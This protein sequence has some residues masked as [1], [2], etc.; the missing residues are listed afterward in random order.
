MILSPVPPTINTKSPTIFVINTDVN[1]IVQL[2][3]LSKIN[4]AKYTPRKPGMAPAVFII[5]V[6]TEKNYRKYSIFHDQRKTTYQTPI[7]KMTEQYL[8]G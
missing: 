5:P 2:P 3:E 8:V 7:L 6:K 1:T 4:P